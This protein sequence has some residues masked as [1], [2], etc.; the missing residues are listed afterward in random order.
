VW[1]MPVDAEQNHRVLR[2]NFVV[3]FAMSTAALECRY[4]GLAPPR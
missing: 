3:G 1:S 2:A 4:R